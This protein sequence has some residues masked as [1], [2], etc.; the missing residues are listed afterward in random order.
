VHQLVTE[1]VTVPIRNLAA[2]WHGKRIVQ[3]SDLHAGR[4]SMAHINRAL[5]TALDLQPEIIVITGDFVDNNR[6]DPAELCEALRRVT[7]KVET[8]GITGNHDFSHIFNNLAFVNR[9][10][11]ALLGAGVRMLRNGIFQPRAGKGEICFVGVE[12]YWSGRLN[13]ETVRHAPA[14]SAVVVLSHNPDSYEILDAFRFDLMLSGHTHG[15]QVCVPFFGP[16]ILPVEHRERAAGLFHLNPAF[17]ERALYVSR[18]VGHILQVR[19]F[20]PPEVTCFTLRNPAM[21]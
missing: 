3:L 7:A 5:E 20:C 17:P 14:D 16:L 13:A 19:L 12:D 18:G 2:R 9:V 10:C 4:T 1:H 6:V 8:L 15:G 21:P 11:D